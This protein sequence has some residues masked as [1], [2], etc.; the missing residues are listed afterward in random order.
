VAGTYAV[1]VF[2]AEQDGTG[3]YILHLQR[4]TAGQRC[5]NPLTCG[6]ETTTTIDTRADTDLH[7][8]TGEGGASVTINIE[9]LGGTIL[10]GPVWRLLAPDGSPTASCGSIAS[11]SRDCALPGGGSY[12][13]EVFDADQ[14]GT[15]SYMLTVSGSGCVSD[16]DQPNLQVSALKGKAVAG[17]GLTY[18]ATD[19]TKNAGTA[20]APASA[21]KL[22]ISTNDTWDP[23]DTL[24]VPVVG[25]SVP[26]LTSGTT[27]T[28]AT[29][30]TIP[31]G[32]PSGKW[33]LIAFADAAGTIGESSET[34]NTKAKTVYV[35]PD[36]RVKKLTS[37]AAAAR[38]QVISVTDTTE[39]SGGAPTSGVRV[40][41][42]YL[43]KNKKLDASNVG[44]GPGR[45][46]PVL[47][48]GATSMATT[49]V[50]I[51][52]ATTPGA[53][54]LLA[55]ADDGNVEAEGR[56][57]NNVKAQPITIN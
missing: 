51:P 43:S 6:V 50:T 57:N 35:G 53:Y 47:A 39:N 56:E 44:L 21:T 55:V 45:N 30:V 49:N 23:G 1:E 52:A 41:R 12:A 26:A 36:L 32:T 5:A 31:P 46:V 34:D 16:A 17:A 27:S 28:G 37:P 11:W 54:Y 48:A 22:Y 9:R 19:T 3:T 2:D 38:G 40:T 10:F 24:L 15:G 18:K 25:R 14:N 29:M 4:L 13:V 20:D 42:F 8:F 7:G 33:F